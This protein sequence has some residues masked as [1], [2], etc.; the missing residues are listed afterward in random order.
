MSDIS[1]NASNESPPSTPPHSPQQTLEYVA[2]DIAAGLMGPAQPISPR[3][4]ANTLANFNGNPGAANLITLGLLET[5]KEHDQKAIQAVNERDQAYNAERR[6]MQATINRLQEK[7]ELLTPD[8][9]PN[10]FILNGEGE[11]PDFCLPI[12]EGYSQPAYWIKR[13]PNGQ[14]AGLP[15][16]CQPGDTPFVGDIYAGRATPRPL[17]DNGYTNPVFPLPA[18]L[19]QLLHGPSANFATLEQE[20]RTN[21]DWGMQAEVARYRALHHSVQD[22]EVRMAERQ[23]ELRSV[24]K[25]KELCQGRLELARLEDK[26]AELRV[27]HPAGNRHS[28][29]FA[30]SNRGGFNS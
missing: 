6:K 18:W 12:Q 15:Q 5:I 30:R 17:E 29:Q 26:V 13:L 10:G 25:C 28:R 23:A 7:V 22:L 24:Q 21:A 20:V 8:N 1:R 27:L 14:V 11:A 3:T 16:D 2:A 9:P 4:A 19:L